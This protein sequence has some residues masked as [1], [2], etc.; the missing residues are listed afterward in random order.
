MSAKSQHTPG[1]WQFKRTEGFEEQMRLLKRQYAEHDGYVRSNDGTWYILDSEGNQVA[2]ATF[3]GEAKRGKGYAAPDPE[4]MQN[5]RLIAAAPDL[6]TALEEIMAL[7][8]G[9]DTGRNQGIGEA[10]F[11]ASA[12]IEILRTPA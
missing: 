7:E 2:M 6:L 3:K 11:Y 5:A 8:P 9:D 12:A 10:Q 1:P 4:G